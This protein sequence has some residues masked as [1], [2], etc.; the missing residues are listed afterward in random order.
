M[1][2]L[3]K[4]FQELHR[5]E[6]RGGSGTDCREEG[7]KGTGAE[8]PGARPGLLLSIIPRTHTSIC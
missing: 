1:G 4:G 6:R 3:E 8:A 5:V 2:I 7:R